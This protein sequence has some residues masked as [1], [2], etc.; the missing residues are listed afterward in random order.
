V[1]PVVVAAPEEDRIADLI[2]LVERSDGSGGFAAH[3][4]THVRGKGGIG[5]NGTERT[6]MTSSIAV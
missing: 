5:D 1:L 3:I 4:T 2:S 6:T